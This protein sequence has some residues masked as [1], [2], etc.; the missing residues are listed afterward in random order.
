MVSVKALRKQVD[1]DSLHSF[2]AN[3]L[4]KKLITNEFN[5][6]LFQ[7]KV[8]TS[9]TPH[10]S[11]TINHTSSKSNPGKCFVSSLTILATT[12]ILL[13]HQ[14]SK[15]TYAA[16]NKCSQPEPERRSMKQTPR[17]AEGS[18]QILSQL[19]Q[20]ISNNMELLNNNDQLIQSVKP[21]TL[22]KKSIK[23][24]KH[25]AKYAKLVQDFGSKVVFN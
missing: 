18:D 21:E 25:P 19:Q 5:R 17:T 4:E 1:I 22:S 12:D 11:L 7:E 2:R 24:L 23:M 13:T 20:I 8:R 9:L 15:K 3:R 14:T 16:K 10:Q 6:K